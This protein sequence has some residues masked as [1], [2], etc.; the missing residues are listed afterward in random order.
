[1]SHDQP[2]DDHPD[3]HLLA[4]FMRNAADAPERRRVVRHLLAGCA[5]CAAVTRQLWDLGEP[6]V[7]QPVPQER[8]LPRLREDAAALHQE[9]RRLVEAGR[10]PEALQALQR[11]RRLY[12][13]LGDG[14][15]LVRLRHLE[16]KIGEAL[17]VPG[18]AEIAFADARRGFLLEGLGGEAAE[19]L[20]DLAILYARQGRSLEIRALAADLM[21]ILRTRDLR[22]GV[23]AALLFFRSLA[24]TE[25]A[26]PEALSEISRYVRPAGR[27]QA[28]PADGTG[29]VNSSR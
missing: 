21:P 29:V 10:G 8:D 9:A 5:R 6:P 4:R 20:L 26:T 2:E 18:E 15:N 13:R 23:G 28:A 12:Q 16:G 19:A 3:P 25:H 22:Q 1:M 27:P 7:R 17:G 11:A 24:E 14:P